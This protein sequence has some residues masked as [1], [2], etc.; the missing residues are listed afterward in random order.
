MTP[1]PWLN[2][3]P[4]VIQSGL[5]LAWVAILVA[6]CRGLGARIEGFI[7]PIE[8]HPRRHSAF[9]FA[10]QT[11]LGLGAMAQL[12][13][14]LSLVGLVRL[15]V[16]AALAVGFWWW[17]HRGQPGR[18]VWACL[19]DHGRWPALALVLLGVPFLLC[20]VPELNFDALR[21]HL[22]L[23]RELAATGLLPVEP[24]NW[25]AYIPNATAVLFGAAGLAGGEVGAKL[26]HFCLGVLIALLPGVFVEERL[27][28]G[29]TWL[30][31]AFWLVLPVVM[32]EMSSAYTDLGVTLF[33]F[34]AIL[35][36]FRWRRFGTEGWLTLAAI[37]MGLALTAKPT[38]LPWLGWL[39][40]AV[41]VFGAFLRRPRRDVLL[42]AGIFVALAVLIVAPW[43]FRTYFLTGNPLFPIPLPGFHSDLITPAIVAE[44]RREQLAF[45]FGREWSALVVLP[46]NLL[47]RP[48]AFRGGPGPLIF[49][50]LPLLA[51]WW[52]RSSGWDRWFALSFGFGTLVWFFT[53]QEI[54]YLMPVLPLAA[55]LILRPLVLGERWGRGFQIAWGAGLVLQ[56]VYLSPLVYPW[57][58]PDVPFQ[59]RVGVAELKTAAGIMPRA[60]YLAARNSFFPVYD[61][62]NRNLTGS[63]RL[64]SFDAAAYWSRWPLLYAFSKEGEFAGTEH[65]PDVILTRCHRA[66]LTHVIVNSDWLTPDMDRRRV[67]EFF[68]PEFQDRYLQLVHA[69]GPVKLFA[70]PPPA[71]IGAAPPPA[72][73]GAGP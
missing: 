25:N 2:V 59:V 49:L 5:A 71:G 19:R 16:V 55:W 58:H 61:W 23:A 63:V 51:L 21:T 48:E 34:A 28:P 45:G 18:P 64:L 43:L 42:H 32:W 7:L 67:S 70:I 31:A 65:D 73:A 54:R 72:P 69:R 66:R 17:G 15:P 37:F 38:A 39:T 50:A 62:A 11:A 47:I 10:F 41:L 22:W 40:G 36:L 4:A 56:L 9:T 8:E 53:A 14:G 3:L 68:K 1:L 52:R 20:F 44:V 29:G 12:L 6:G 27:E 24:S 60:E 30:F 26:L 35:C 13:Y 33:L 57:V 46:W